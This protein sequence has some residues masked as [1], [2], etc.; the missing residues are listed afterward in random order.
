MTHEYS[1]DLPNTNQNCLHIA[2]I[3]TI[4]IHTNQKGWNKSCT[5]NEYD[6]N[7]RMANF[8]NAANEPYDFR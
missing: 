2:T 7:V 4:P 5:S 1:S 8:A 6:F 3:D